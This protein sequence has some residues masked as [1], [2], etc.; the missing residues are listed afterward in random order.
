MRNKIVKISFFSS[1]LLLSGCSVGHY[2]YSRTALNKTDMNFIGIP[3]ILGVGMLGSSV[4]IT[5]EYSLTAA[6][7]AKYMMYKVKSYHPTCDLAII[8]HKNKEKE[9]PKFRNSTIGENIDMY[10]YS[11]YTAMPVESKGKTLINVRVGSK[12]NKSDCTL[13]A[14][15]SGVV[16]GMSGGAVYNNKDNTLAGIIQGY[17]NSIKK[18]NTPSKELYKNVSLYI[19]YNNFSSWLEKET[20]GKYV[21]TNIEHNVLIFDKK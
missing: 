11:I 12:W 17:S 1:I 21:Y 6:H 4:P 10:G 20:G 14:S 2:E 9:Y 7:V 13:V 3:T 19:P 8:Y 16:Q 15:N 5:P 18:I